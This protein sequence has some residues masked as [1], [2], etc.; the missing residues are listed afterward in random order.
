M[1]LAVWHLGAGDN[2]RAISASLLLRH[3]WASGFLIGGWLLTGR[4]VR[5]ANPARRFTLGAKLA[6]VRVRAC[7]DVLKGLGADAMRRERVR[8]LAAH[9]APIVEAH[10]PWFGFL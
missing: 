2:R 9:M 6:E 3:G 8:E 10:H 7:A 4:V 1:R 5:G